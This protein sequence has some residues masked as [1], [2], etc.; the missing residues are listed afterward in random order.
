MTPEFTKSIM[1]LATDVVVLVT[2]DISHPDWTEDLHLVN[3]N[4]AITSGATIYEPYGFEF[5]PA[6]PSQDSTTSAT[7]TIEDIDRRLTLGLR[8]VTSPADI[9]INVVSVD[10]VGVVTI[11][12]GP[13]DFSIRDT[14]INGSAINLSLKTPSVLDNRLSGYYID[15]IDFPGFFI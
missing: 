7:L 9:S 4:V 6:N 14:T 8:S 5:I 10:N 3:N 15:S 1:N 13:F 2:L 12:M 11:E